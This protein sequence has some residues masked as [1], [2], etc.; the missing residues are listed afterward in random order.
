MRK[1]GSPEVG[2]RRMEEEGEMGSERRRG[3]VVYVGD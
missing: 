2:K 1:V 3:V